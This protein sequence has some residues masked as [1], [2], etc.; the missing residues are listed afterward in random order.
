MS[1]QETFLVA[2]LS[3]FAAGALYGILMA[4]DNS[5]SG[6][7]VAIVAGLILGVGVFAIVVAFNHYRSQR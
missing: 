5:A 2:L 1:R 7:V 4:N 3:L 6:Q